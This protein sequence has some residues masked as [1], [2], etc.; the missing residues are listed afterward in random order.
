[1]FTQLAIAGKS[2]LTVRGY[3]YP[4][5]SRLWAAD[6]HAPCVASGTAIPPAA[7]GLTLSGS[8]AKLNRSNRSVRRR[9]PALSLA[10]ARA[11]ERALVRP[12]RAWVAGSHL[13]PPPP[14][15]QKYLGCSGYLPGPTGSLE[16]ELCATSWFLLV[17]AAARLEPAWTAGQILVLCVLPRRAAA[18]LTRS[19]W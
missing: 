7:L 9:L 15:S 17:P 1:M 11:S 5:R 6:C 4:P 16:D 19:S 14:L 10:R 8:W 12:S 3:I 2:C 13:S 18:L